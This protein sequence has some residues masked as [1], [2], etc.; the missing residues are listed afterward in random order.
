MVAAATPRPE[1]SRGKA[2]GVWVLRVAIALLFLFA[3][4]MKL[5]GQPMM[6]AEFDTIGLGQWFRYFTGLVEVAGALL[7]LWPRYTGLGALI[8]LAVDV[9]AFFAQVLALHGD[10]IHTVVIGAVLAALIY[11]TRRAIPGFSA[12]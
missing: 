5:I 4:T 11:L 3:A 9:G 8:L 2:I 7:V 1:H 12:R 10:W 6:V